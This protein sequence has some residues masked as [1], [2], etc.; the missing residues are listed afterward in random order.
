M[1]TD[2][3]L[4]RASFFGMANRPT[5][6]P[7]V[8]SARGK[9][10]TPPCASLEQPHWCML[11][12][13]LWKLHAIHVETLVWPFDL[14]NEFKLWLFFSTWI[15][16]DEKTLL[17]E[18]LEGWIITA[19]EDSTWSKH[20]CLDAWAQPELISRP[21]PVPVLEFKVFA[22]KLQAD[23]SKRAQSS[24]SNFTLK[25][26][27]NKRRNKVWHNVDG[28]V[29][30]KRGHLKE[31]FGVPLR[32]VTSHD[33]LC[34][35]HINSLPFRLTAALTQLISSFGTSVICISLRSRY[36]GGKWWSCNLQLP[37]TGT[38]LSQHCL[39]ISWPSHDT[40]ACGSLEVGCVA[41]EA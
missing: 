28:P 30:T 16:E 27:Q 23:A 29:N 37:C 12:W 7:K 5:G 35:P 17:L 19:G 10:C 38:R 21:E 11:N 2:I 14:A 31:S 1:L 41:F 40:N 18:E 3:Q 39:L 24:I 9:R 34:M 13:S 4:L 32:L 8:I 6:N 33:M 20:S 25:L 22:L 26:S 15:Q 36:L